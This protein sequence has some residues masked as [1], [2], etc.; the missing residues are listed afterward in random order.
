[1]KIFFSHRSRQKSL[2]REI[3]QSLPNHLDTWID[4]DELLIGD[5]IT[6]SIALAIA[7][8]SDYVLLLLDRDTAKSR[9]VQQEIAW[10]LAAESR[11]N[12]RILLPVVT[13]DEALEGLP[14]ALADRRHLKLKDNDA[15]SVTELATRIASELFALICR[16]MELLKDPSSRRSTA[17]IADAEALL[18]EQGKLIQHIVFPHRSENPISKKAML[19]LFN[20]DRGQSAS[21]ADFDVILKHVL[22]RNLLPG[23]YYDGNEAYLTRE[24][25]SWKRDL[26]RDEKRRIARVLAKSI[27][28]GMAVLMDAGTTNEEV[29]EIVCR[30]IETRVLTN[31]T[32]ASTS[33]NIVDMIS[34]CCV[35][36]GF[37]EDFSPVRLYMPGGRVSPHSQAIL[38]LADDGPRPLDHLVGVI[39]E[40]DLGVVGVNGIDADGVCTTTREAEAKTK[41]DIIRVSSKTVAVADSSKIGRVLPCGF[42][43]LGEEIDQLIVDEVSGNEVLEQLLQSYPDVIRLAQ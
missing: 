23:L 8:D 39:G 9:W 20:Y 25:V 2:V 3:R 27:R 31:I 13:E 1:M 32:M 36:M 14:L 17:A 11:C 40:F 6:T 18:S 4:E 37:S 43:R 29:V 42:A 10:A 15:S 35:A 30:N 24:H 19:D 38:P 26:Q 22:Q 33:V 12:R 41:R 7:E 5:D 21:E 28:S 34:D 16:D